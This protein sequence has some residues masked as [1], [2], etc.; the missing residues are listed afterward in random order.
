MRRLL[1][2]SFSFEE[3]LFSGYAPDG[4]LYVPKSVPKLS[5]EGID[6]MCCESLSYC[7]L[8]H[9]VLS[10]YI[11][12]DE[13][14]GKTLRSMIDS[15]FATFN[16]DNGEDVIEMVKL[17]KNCSILE[18]FHGPTGAFKDLSF[19]LLSHL[20][21][22]FMEKRKGDGKL[23]SA[24]VV[25]LVGTSGDTGPAAIHAVRGKTGAEIVA[26]YPQGRV[27]EIQELQMLSVEDA[28]VHV[29]ACEGTSDDLDIPIKHVFNDAKF[30]S[31]NNL[32]VVNSI[33]W[34][35]VMMQI[36]HFFYGFVLAK[37]FRKCD[38]KEEPQR[39]VYSVPTG[40]CG[41][42]SG[43]IIAQKMGL[44]V[45][46][47]IGSNENDIIVRCVKT[48][49]YSVAGNVRP[50][51][52][53]AIDIQ[54]PYNWERI[55]A[56]LFPM[57]LEVTI[58]DIFERFSNTGRVTFPAELHKKI[59]SKFAARS[60]SEEETADVIRHC[61]TQNTTKQFVHT[62]RLVSKQ[63][64]KRTRTAT[65]VTC[66]QLVSSCWPQLRPTNSWNLCNS[67]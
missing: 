19:A 37:K 16:H 51:M 54:L 56:T 13:V 60:V 22:Y 65:T 59:K 21:T 42:L 52:S 23:S 34:G 5:R 57:E 12:E 10:Y 17:E 25:F 43:G 46:F 28:N 33:N 7:D 41:N 32:C 50:C 61:F 39:V 58:R 30:A 9:K 31:D 20:F 2:G 6:E 4:G 62:L 18:L 11:G 24:K 26:L 35:R 27:S 47:V 15:A 55:F 8:C 48:G 67:V 44:P 3:V 1:A 49:E 38:G 53:S 64:T 36:V 45:N 63:F 40:A 66:C 29:F 14:P